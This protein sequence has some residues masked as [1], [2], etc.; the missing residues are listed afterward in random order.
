MYE[1]C[2]FGPTAFQICFSVAFF[3]GL[4]P[5]FGSVHFHW[6]SIVQGMSPIY[7]YIYVYFIPFYTIFYTIFLYHLHSH[8][9][10]CTQ[11]KCRWSVCVLCLYECVISYS[12]KYIPG[13]VAQHL[14]RQKEKEKLM[15]HNMIIN[16]QARYDDNH[17]SLIYPALHH[18][19]WLV[20]LQYYLCLMW[21][22]INWALHMT[23]LFSHFKWFHSKQHY[24]LLCIFFTWDHPFI[25]S[26]INDFF[27]RDITAIL[28]RQLAI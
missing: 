11:L 24:H 9:S 6:S 10:L 28:I 27:G 20:S 23:L 22:L 26:V 18:I 1:V 15:Q 2:P 8:I 21:H 17:I 14:W 4:F 3:P 16:R 7:I 13:A 5:L 19:H 25:L 12:S